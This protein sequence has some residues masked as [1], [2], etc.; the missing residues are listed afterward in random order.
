M[1][2]FTHQ[3]ELSFA[4][5]AARVT[6][7]LSRDFR[8]EIFAAAYIWARENY[9]DFDEARG[10]G[11]IESRLKYW[12]WGI[13]RNARKKILRQEAPLGNA[14]ALE[15]LTSGDD[16]EA[17]ASR[18]EEIEALSP[19]ERAIVTTLCDG[20]SVRQAAKTHRVNVNKVKK[21]KRRV[22]T[23]LGE[24]RAAPV[25][26]RASVGSSDDDTREPAPIDLALEHAD[27]IARPRAHGTK[28]CP[29][30]LVCLW[31]EGF[32]VGVEPHRCIEPEIAEAIRATHERK[33]EIS[34]GWEHMHVPH[35][36][37]DAHRFNET[38]LQEQAAA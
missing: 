16:P 35:C 4:R 6:R 2:P 18:D 1:N 37:P 11:S 27:N 20:A 36:A 5:V 14:D 22:R 30:C 29:P 21:L 3:Q 38:I 17:N 33:V 28:N 34:A 13:C 8:D 10:E 12:F 31:W 23:L 32:R 7:R 15:E 25:Y 19:E 26:R 9:D 24:N